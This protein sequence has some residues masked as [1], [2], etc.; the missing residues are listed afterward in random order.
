MQGMRSSYLLHSF[1]PVCGFPFFGFF[2]P[3]HSFY[4][5]SQPFFVNSAFVASIL[6]VLIYTLAPHVAC[7]Y[8][9]VCAVFEM[10]QQKS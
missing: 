8:N 1:Y 2:S 9:T 3:L 4:L 7:F 5:L 6:S 10:I